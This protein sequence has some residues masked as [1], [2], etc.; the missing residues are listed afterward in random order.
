[1]KRPSAYLLIPLLA[2]ALLGTTPT[3]KDGSVL[4][5]VAPIVPD[6]SMIATVERKIATRS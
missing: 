6:P 5:S 2:C 3:L 4:A 1:M